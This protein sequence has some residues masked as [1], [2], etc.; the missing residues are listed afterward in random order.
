MLENLETRKGKGRMVDRDKEAEEAAASLVTLQSS[1][2]GNTRAIAPL[3][4]E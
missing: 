2:D 3:A 1:A 4:V